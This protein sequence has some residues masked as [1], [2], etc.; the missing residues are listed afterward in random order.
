M[1]QIILFSTERT[2]MLS[3]SIRPVVH[4]FLVNIKRWIKSVQYIFGNDIESCALSHWIEINDEME[5]N[6]RQTRYNFSTIVLRV[7]TKPYDCTYSVFHKTCI[8][9]VC[10]IVVWPT[11]LENLGTCALDTCPSHLSSELNVV[12]ARLVHM[13]T[14]RA[15][16]SRSHNATDSPKTTQY[17]PFT[18]ANTIS[19]I[20]LLLNKI[21]IKFIYNNA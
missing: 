19:H 18:T 1:E 5:V 11:K 6:V 20:F 8:H 2:K 3:P 15:N 13:L 21:Q 12:F 17:T 10:R 4:L 14:I 7:A 9:S 16:I